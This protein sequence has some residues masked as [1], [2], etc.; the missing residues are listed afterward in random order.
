M[1]SPCRGCEN[2]NRSKIECSKGCAKL[3]TFQEW[4]FR[5]GYTINGVGASG[6][7]PTLLA[8]ARA[9]SPAKHILR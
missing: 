9:A 6:P 2:E 7:Q 4:D 5:Q 3:N 1:V 8:R